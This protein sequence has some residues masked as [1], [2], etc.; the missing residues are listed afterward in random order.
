MRLGAALDRLCTLV[1]L[2]GGLLLVALIGVECVSVI[3]RSLPELLGWTGLGLHPRSVPGD[4]EIAQALTATALFSFLPFCQMR[5][6]HIRVEVF[7][8]Y[9]PVWLNAALDRVWT[10]AFAVLAAVLAWRLMLGWLNKWSHGDTT[11]V[12]RIPEVLPF[13]AAVAGTLLL[14]AAVLMSFS[15]PRR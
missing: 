2:G 1:A 4:A 14:L 15:Q 8:Q 6:G 3:G 12:L 5:G 11:M 7:S 13:G 10:A 9:F